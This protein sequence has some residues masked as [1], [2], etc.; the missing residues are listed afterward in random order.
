MK[1][2]LTFLQVKIVIFFILCSFLAGIASY[3]TLIGAEPIAKSFGYITNNQLTNPVKLNGFILIGVI[4]IIGFLLGSIS[5]FFMKR[6]KNPKIFVIFFSIL[7]LICEL[8][9]AVNGQTLTN[10]GISNEKIGLVLYIIFYGLSAFSFAIIFNNAIYCIN[11]VLSHDKKLRFR[12]TT[13]GH[14]CWAIGVVI[15]CISIATSSEVK[16]I[17]NWYLFHY[18]GAAI[19]LLIILNNLTIKQEN[20]KIE[21]LFAN[22]QNKAKNHENDSEIQIFQ[23]PKLINFEDELV[24]YNEKLSQMQ[25][26]AF[27]NKKN[28]ENEGLN[29][30]L[31]INNIEQK[32]KSEVDEIE[33]KKTEN[34]GRYAFRIL[35]IILAIFVIGLFQIGISYWLPYTTSKSTVYSSQF[36]NYTEYIYICLGFFV[37]VAFSSFIYGLTAKWWAKLKAFY[38]VLVLLILATI[39]FGILIFNLTNWGLTLIIILATVIG[40]FYSISNNKIMTTFHD[41]TESPTYNVWVVGNIFLALGFLV[42]ISYGYLIYSSYSNVFNLVTM[43]TSFSFMVIIIFGLLIITTFKIKSKVEGRNKK[44][45]KEINELINF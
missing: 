30:E 36:N 4:P 33:Y 14:T 31:K 11:K 45:T 37:G 1:V 43:I 12:Y 10:N 42:L 21:D 15:V 22:V 32:F 8:I 34:N 39:T 7:V 5:A 29:K 26:T 13:W 25:V 2:K 20:F 28:K 24:K 44:T 17:N 38:I 16:A 40:V 19:A 6:F 18:L 23:K 3:I 27:N 9:T 35:F 41:E